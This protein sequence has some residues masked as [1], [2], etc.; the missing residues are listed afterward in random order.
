MNRGAV[1]GRPAGRRAGLAVA[2]ILVFIAGIVLA[3]LVGIYILREYNLANQCRHNMEQIYMAVEMYE[4]NSGALP[5][6][7]F[8]PENSRESK[9]SIRFSL[10]QHGAPN[11]AFLCPSSP[12]VVK[13]F[14]LSYIWNVRLNG[15]SFLS[16]PEPTWMLVEINAISRSV[17]PPHL[18]RYN[19]LY[20]D[21]RVVPSFKPPPELK[22]LLEG[23]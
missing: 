10:T 18:A 9:D 11:D 2:R 4:V 15:K 16:I 17:P 21:G 3:G 23:Y 20:T 5:K 13:D 14:G 19:I 8:F 7:A 1:N 22:E 6:L 12:E